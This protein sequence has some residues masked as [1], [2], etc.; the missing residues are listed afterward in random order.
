MLRRPPSSTLFPSTTLFRSV[1]VHLL[2]FG[3]DAFGS[4]TDRHQIADL[5]VPHLG[6]ELTV[7]HQLHED[8]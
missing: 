8:L 2:I 3:E 5:Q 4:G 6:G 1:V 7:G